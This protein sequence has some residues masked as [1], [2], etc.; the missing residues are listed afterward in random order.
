M[1]ISITV[2]LTNMNVYGW[3]WAWSMTMPNYRNKRII[4]FPRV[5]I[6][7]K[8]TKSIVSQEKLVTRPDRWIIID[9]GLAS[10]SECG[11]MSRRAGTPTPPIQLARYGGAERPL[12]FADSWTLASA[13]PP[14]K[15]RG[16]YNIHVCDRDPCVQWC[17]K[18][19]FVLIHMSCVHALNYTYVVL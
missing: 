14:R 19:D 12:Q 5:N 15:R 3:D 10:A 2:T 11:W 4:Y 9:L 18:Y 7:N 8:F 17:A 6:L 13:R 1:N 16:E